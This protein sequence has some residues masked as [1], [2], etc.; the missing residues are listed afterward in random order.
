MAE[1]TQGNKRKAEQMEQTVQESEPKAKKLSGMQIPSEKWLEYILTALEDNGGKKMSNAAF[2]NALWEKYDIDFSLDSNK[3]ALALHL[4]VFVKSKKL[5]KVKASYIK[6]QEPKYEPKP[7]PTAFQDYDGPIVGGHIDCNGTSL[8]GDMWPKCKVSEVVDAFGYTPSKFASSFFN[9]T[10]QDS[11]GNPWTL[12]DWKMKFYMT[13]EEFLRK[14]GGDDFV[15]F[16]IGG[17]PDA[18]PTEFVEFLIKSVKLSSI[19]IRDWNMPESLKE[20]MS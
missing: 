9:W 1:S 7:N 16:N 10:F 18:D 5:Q 14:T 20:L 4:G 6:F 2:K 8:R 19:D 12:Y 13:E 3:Y 15:F 11:N 17:N